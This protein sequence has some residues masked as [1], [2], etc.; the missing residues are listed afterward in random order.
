[1]TLSALSLAMLQT[2][3]ATDEIIS[4]LFLVVPMILILYFFMIKPQNDM[5]KRHQAM[6]EGVRR[7]DRIVT[8]G[9][10]V[11]KVTKVPENSEEITVQLA[12]GIEVTVMK[13]M[14]NDVKSKT[15]PAEKTDK[16]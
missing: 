5:R 7:G 1:M 11:G 10:L 15:Q 8:A 12:D 4:T 13:G 14:L 16:K 3:S 6:V 9:G 2:R